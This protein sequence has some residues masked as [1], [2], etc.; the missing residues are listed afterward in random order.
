MSGNKGDKSSSEQ[1][2]INKGFLNERLATKGRASHP[3]HFSP[4]TARAYKIAVNHYRFT[5]G[6]LLPTS[7]IEIVDYLSASRN[8]FS[9]STLQIHLSALSNWHSKQGFADPTKDKVIREFMAH[10]K[11]TSGHVPCRRQSVSFNDLTIMDD[12]LNEDGHDEHSNLLLPPSN[13]QLRSLRDRVILLLGYWCSLSAKQ[14]VDLEI[15]DLEISNT[16]GML[17][18]LSPSTNH[19]VKVLVPY[20]K[21]NCP[22]RAAKEWMGV[23]LSNR[24]PLLRPIDRWG[25]IKNDKLNS[26]SINLILETV[27][28]NSGVNARITSTGLRNGLTA[29][30]GGG[31][32]DR[33]LILAHAGWQGYLSRHV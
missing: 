5:C 11:R 24:G 9:P 31:S 14:I 21:H 2:F 4:E 29:N 12:Y 27:A 18:N 17:I 6:R 23:M 28:S 22:V 3:P 7:A 15:T 8:S 20:L 26:Q 13:K 19:Q 33:E 1:A 25:E 10:I 32:W 16:Q 30:E